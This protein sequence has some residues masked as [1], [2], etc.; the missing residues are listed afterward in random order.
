[1]PLQLQVSLFLSMHRR[2]CKY[3]RRQIY[4][5]NG[6]RFHW[7][8]LELRVKTEIAP[9]VQF[10]NTALIPLLPARRGEIWSIQLLNAGEYDSGLFLD[11][12]RFHLAPI[13]FFPL[14]PSLVSVISYGV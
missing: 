13:R 6:V 11:I 2:N 5:R 7:K 8:M 4:F 12:V 1:M 10:L 14:L 9:R 3:Q